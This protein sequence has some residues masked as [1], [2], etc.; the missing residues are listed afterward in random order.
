MPAERAMPLRLD[1]KKKLSART[2]SCGH[3]SIMIIISIMAVMVITIIIRIHI[4]LY[5]IIV[6]N[7]RPSYI[8][9]C[10]MILY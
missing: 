1:I 3:A 5:Y 6:Y 2:A 7:L 9:V 4:I 8:I 10:Y